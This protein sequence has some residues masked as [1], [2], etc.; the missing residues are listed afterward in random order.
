MVGAPVIA[1]TEREREEGPPQRPLIPGLPPRA[2][3]ITAPDLEPDG[4]EGAAAETADTTSGSISVEPPTVPNRAAVAASAPMTSAVPTAVQDPRA[5]ARVEMQLRA[6]T[7]RLQA[8]ETIAGVA[9]PEWQEPFTPKVERAAPAEQ[10]DPAQPSDPV[11]DAGDAEPEDAAEAGDEAAAAED[12]LPKRVPGQ[13]PVISGF[14]SRAA[15]PGQKPSAEPAATES[16]P[17]EQDSASAPGAAPAASADDED[18]DGLP[19]FRRTRSTPTPPQ[20]D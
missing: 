13:Q 12:A 7:A 8:Q 5:A 19:A 6:R 9:V 15:D 14:E 3:A 20:D 18:A 10:E 2:P 11:A 1:V 17:A 4:E 16:P